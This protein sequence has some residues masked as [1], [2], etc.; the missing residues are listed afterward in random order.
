MFGDDPIFSSHYILRSTRCRFADR[1]RPQETAPALL[2]TR[3]VPPSPVTHHK[4]MKH[5]GHLGPSKKSPL[6]QSRAGRGV[7]IVTRGG[8]PARAL[9]R[10]RS[11]TCFRRSLLPRP[12]GSDRSLPSSYCE[13]LF[14]RVAYLFLVLEHDEVAMA[15]ITGR[16]IATPHS[17]GRCLHDVDKKTAR[18]AST[19]GTSS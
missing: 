18:A 7:R 12:D 13:K 1:C 3:V 9:W 11:L 4:C 2:R 16:R 15:I 8:G 5:T 19:R 6:A 10:R 17:D 14:Q